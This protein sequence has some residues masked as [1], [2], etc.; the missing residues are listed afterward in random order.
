MTDF[1]PYFRQEPGPLAAVTA[2]G[3]RLCVEGLEVWRALHDH[4]PRQGLPAAV[5]D[6]L[7]KDVSFEFY[8]KDRNASVRFTGNAAMC[9]R[10]PARTAFR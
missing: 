6:S 8:V 3:T 5:D 4:R 7:A 1:T 2:E 10:A 9:C